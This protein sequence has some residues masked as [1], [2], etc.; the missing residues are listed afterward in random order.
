MLLNEGV[1]AH[2]G[3]VQIEAHLGTPSAS[4]SKTRSRVYRHVDLHLTTKQ[5]RLWN[6]SIELTVAAQ[7]TL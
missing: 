4:D 3:A 2:A 6:D 5:L 1:S 7:M